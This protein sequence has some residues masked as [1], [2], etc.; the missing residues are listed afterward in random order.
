[1]LRESVAARCQGELRTRRTIEG[2]GKWVD[3]KR[4]LVSAEVGS[5]AETLAAAGVV[6]ELVPLRIQLR[7]TDSG[8]AKASEALETLLGKSE[9]PA[10]IVRE[11]LLWRVGD[12]VGT[13]LEIE[14]ARSVRQASGVPMFEAEAAAPV[15]SPAA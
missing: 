6:G 14:R 10:R 5:G 9:V 1:M 7:I 15:G 3:V 13:P 4:Y 8:S 12:S 11:K 2:I